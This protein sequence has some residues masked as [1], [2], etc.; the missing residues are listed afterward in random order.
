[1]NYLIYKCITRI[2]TAV[3]LFWFL[4]P[5]LI[6]GQTFT[7]VTDPGNPIV[8][9]NLDVNYS[10]AAWVDYDNDGDMDLYT[11]K[12][13]LF[14]NDGN[15]NFTLLTTQIGTHMQQQ[16][17]NGCSWGDYDNDGDI[18]IAIAGKSTLIYKNDGLD[19]FNTVD[20]APL[21]INADHRG[22]TCSWGDY[23]NDGFLDLIIT[24]PS[25]FLG[26][27]EQPCLLLKNNGDGR[28]TNITGYYFTDNIAP[29]TVATWY[30]F[31]Q[32]GDIDLFIAS[33]PANGSGHRDYL[34]RNMLMET[35]T[36]NFVRIDDLVIGTDLQD[37]Q[38][39]NFIDYDNDGDYDA[40]ITNYGGAIDH[41][42]RNDNGTYV[43]VS[44]AMTVAGQH[45][46]NT[47]ADVD[48][49]GDPDV[50]ITGEGGTSFYRNDDGV[51]NNISTAFTLSGS[52]RGATF[53][54][55]DNDGDMDLFV[56]GSGDTKGLFRNDN[57]NG[58]HW[59][60]INCSGTISNWSAIGT[61]IKTKAVI[62][63]NPVWQLRDISGQNSFN[64][65]NSLRVHF[66]LKD[67]VLV[68]SLVI[69][70]PSGQSAVYTNLT[71][72]DIYTFREIIPSG[73]LRC[74]FS[75]D[76][77]SGNDSLT[78]HFTDLSLT[79]TAKPVI[80]WMWDFNNDGT[81]DA[82]EKNPE[83]TYTVPGTYTVKLSISNST[84]TL[85]RTRLDYITINPL[86]GIP[87]EETDIAEKFA[88]YQNFPNPFNPST[89][90]RY[91]V[92]KGQVVSVKVYDVL[93]K[94]IAQLVN[95][96][97][98]P[99]TYQVKF[100]GSKFPSGLYFYRYYAEGFNEVRKMVLL[101]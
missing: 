82:T 79:D 65:Q 34:Y 35:D 90:I 50:A 96:Y 42:Y 61:R 25:G 71:A 52:P 36:V 74:N 13:F 20:E 58:N 32:D 76:R 31:D 43:S 54:D 44:N 21:S 12:R 22:W 93:G 11:T 7:K 8:T 17:G 48:N 9:T 23:D 63:G 57:T 100:D 98:T 26:S 45:L 77:I 6:F 67:A 73:F 1:M 28:F 81:I 75:A 70:W 19:L 87:S 24:H 88:L 14:R 72:D 69:L 4:G 39:W 59:I 101:K 33:G 92:G 46:A 41:F 64:S 27:P 56:S 15:G 62:N 80:S 85:S 3:F 66:G 30:D 95:E 94:E 18:D 29:Y 16:L 10:G 97:K 55:Y 2:S 60:E 91:I 86:T 40:F 47:W 83:W 38:V 5:L 99:G 78:V 89:S 53:G 84:S 51:F 68:D 49:D 37:G